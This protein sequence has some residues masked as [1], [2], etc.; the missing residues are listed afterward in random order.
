MRQKQV[1]NFCCMAK[2]GG[3][4]LWNP[5]VFFRSDTQVTKIKLIT[6]TKAGL[7]KCQPGFLCLCQIY[8][9]NYTWEGALSKSI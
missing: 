2:E 9:S 1:D 3:A 7:L 4:L 5:P 8:S 6:L